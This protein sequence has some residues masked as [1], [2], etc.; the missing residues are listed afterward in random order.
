MKTLLII[1][2]SILITSAVIG[3]IS[4]LTTGASW[5]YD[6]SAYGGYGLTKLEVTNED[7]ILG[8]HS[9]KKLL[10][11]TIYVNTGMMNSPLD[12]F[13]ETSYAYEENNIIYGYEPNS[14]PWVNILYDFN[15]AK[16]DTLE[17]MQ[18][19]SLSP[20][21]FVVDSVGIIGMN[22]LPLTFQDIN[23]PDIFNP[24]QLSK[25]RVIQGLGS[26]NSYF[27][28]S[29]TILQPFD[30]PFYHIRCY[31]DLDIG[32]ITFTSNQVDCDYIEG[33]TS[34]SE[35]TNLKVSVFPNPSTDEIH[36]DCKNHVFGSIELYD[37]NGIKINS[38][39]TSPI[40]ISDLEYGLY[41]IKVIFSENESYVTKVVKSRS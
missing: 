24:G 29:H 41:I 32:V 38:Y 36:I 16:G 22:G 20:G 3:Q 37:L 40:D 25:M 33:V 8:N 31:E 23:F 2:F 34:I 11:T 15:R 9:Y 35:T 6:V 30:A 5:T 10:S 12:T 18:Y 21:P 1:F 28:H 26:I 4:W 7:T 17:F 14:H 19:E 13:I 27:F 39:Q